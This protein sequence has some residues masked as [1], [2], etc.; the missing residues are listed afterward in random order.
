MMINS[1]QVFLFRW[2]GGL[3]AAVAV[4]VL[5][6]GR[7]SPG[8]LF[9]GLTFGLLGEALR[10]W[11]I[12]Y[13][14]GHTRGL[15]VEAPFLATGGPYAHTRNPLYLGNALNSVGVTTACLGRCSPSLAGFLLLLTALSLS[16][17]YGGIIPLE[18]RHLATVH[19]DAY[20]A[21]CR[22]V[23]RFLPGWRPGGPREGRF[24]LDSAL[25]FERWS[26]AWWLLIWVFLGARAFY[27]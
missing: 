6:L 10:F 3:M 8:S 11:S 7:P 13:S 18:E 23:A 21:Y 22:K 27:G 15:T 16:I 24:C 2:R 14:R 20:A 25:Y 26:V 17:V 19:G 12:G 4:T 9:A 1:L 5:V